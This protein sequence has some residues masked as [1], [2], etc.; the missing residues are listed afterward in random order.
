MLRQTDDFA[1]SCTN[2]KTADKIF[3]LIGQKLQLPLEDTPPFETFGLLQ[4]FNGVNINQ[5][6]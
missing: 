1:I 2:Q 4:D 5:T 6:K 3:D